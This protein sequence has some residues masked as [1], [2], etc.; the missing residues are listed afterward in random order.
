MLISVD[1]F[2]VGSQSVCR[3]PIKIF[4]LKTSFQINAYL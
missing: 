2:Y 3:N 1:D 4:N